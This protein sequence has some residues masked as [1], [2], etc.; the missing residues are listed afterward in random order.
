MS[1]N[2]ELRNNKYSFVEN[3]GKDRQHLAWH[4]LGQVF[5]RPMFIN[6]ALEACQANYDVELEPVVA[7]TPAI[8]AQLNAKDD[9]P[10]ILD[11]VELRKM[12]IPGKAATMRTDVNET[13]GIVGDTY[14]IVQNRD[15]F[16]FIDQLCSAKDANRTDVPVIETAGVLGRGERVFVT[17]KF[18]EPIK[19]DNAGN[20][21]VNMYMVFTTTHDGTG[22][23][24]AMVTPIRV[25]CNNTLNYAFKHNSGKISFRHSS[26]VMNR[27]D[28]TQKENAEFV[29]KSLNLYDVYKKNLEADFEHLRNIKISEKQLQDI[30]AEVNLSPDNMTIYKRSGNNIMA[31]GISTRALNRYTAMRDAIESG[32]GQQNL[33]PGNGLW[34]MNGITTYFQNC[35]SYKD[36][37]KKMMSMLNGYVYDKVQTVHEAVL[38]CE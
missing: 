17:A 23:V 24:N 36:D 11:P 30:L 35:A 33:I 31:D 27:L 25:V 34:V 19:L 13:L 7:L 14:G 15:A 6:E 5:D 38:A 16:S 28:L 8:K 37:S 18:P 2:I 22:S 20:D 12:L 3:G 26:Q 29:Y 21:I 10:I 1:A 4:G 32:I 9:T